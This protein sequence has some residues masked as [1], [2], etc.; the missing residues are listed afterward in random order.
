MSYVQNTY[1]VEVVMILK[2]KGTLWDDIFIQSF[3]LFR[4]CT[5]VKIFSRIEEFSNFLFEKKCN[6]SIDKK[7]D[8]TLN[9]Q[10][11]T[12]SNH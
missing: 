4:T 6:K 3:I 2:Q 11:A 5:Y 9:V 8:N 1:I 12:L 7:K 10:Q